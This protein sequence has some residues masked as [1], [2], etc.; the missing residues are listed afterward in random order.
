MGFKKKIVLNDPIYAIAPPHSH[1]LS[2]FRPYISSI[3][4]F[5]IIGRTASYSDSCI[6]LVHENKLRTIIKFIVFFIYNYTD[7]K[8]CTASH[9]CIMYCMTN[10]T[11]MGDI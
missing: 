1:V 11:T 6:V 8:M 3:L 2:F 5:V 9:V 4:S 7:Q 10:T